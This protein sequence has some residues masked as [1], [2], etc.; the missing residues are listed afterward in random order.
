LLV[1]G[2]KTLYL[3]YHQ[4]GMFFDMEHTKDFDTWNKKKIQIDAADRRPFF[5]E[6]EIWFCHLGVNVG[7]EQNGSDEEALR[8]IVI[9]RKFNNTIF[10]AVPLTRTEKNTRYYFRF[11]FGNNIQSTAILSQVKL[12]D[13]KRLSYKIG[14]ISEKDFIELKKKLK[15]LIP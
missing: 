13:G 11:M 2:N 14:D 4:T 1:G 3:F 6:R 5:H 10:L 15:A 12:I 8:P 7:F 9:V